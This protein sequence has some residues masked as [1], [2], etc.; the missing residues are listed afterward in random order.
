M[1]GQNFAVCRPA[2][3]LVGFISHLLPAARARAMPACVRSNQQVDV[4]TQRHP[5]QR[6]TTATVTSSSPVGRYAIAPSAA[7]AT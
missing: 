6:R 1:F 7:R 3:L 5:A 4:R 2:I